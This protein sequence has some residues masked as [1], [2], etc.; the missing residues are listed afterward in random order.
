M[1]HIKKD[2]VVAD[3]GNLRVA[4]KTGDYEDTALIE[5]YD[6]NEPDT[7]AGAFQAQCVKYGNLVYRFN[8]PRELGAEILKIDPDS[9]HSAASF[10][11]L[12]AELLR[13]L[14]NGSLEPSSLDEAVAV[15]KGIVEEKIEEPVVE[16]PEP[17]DP[18]PPI[19]TTTPTT[20]PPVATSTTTPPVGTP[21]TTPPVDTSTSTPPFDVDDS[22]TV[23]TLTPTLDQD[24]SPTEVLDAQIDVPAEDTSILQDVLEVVSPE[25]NDVV[26]S[27]KRK[28]AKLKKKTSPKKTTL[29]KNRRNT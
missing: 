15:E 4:T 28:I 10:V 27:V 17:I 3:N 18:L 13:Q 21:T 11:R 6:I 9:T 22:N 25:I 7:V 26:S 19:D 16:D 23:D 5:F 12:N 2:D 24:I 14:N 29:K 20:T 8:D 1:I